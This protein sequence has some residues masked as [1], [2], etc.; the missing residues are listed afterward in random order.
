MK[1]RINDTVSC[2]VSNPIR[3]NVQISTAW[4]DDF[5]TT[6]F[7]PYKGECSNKA[8]ESIEENIR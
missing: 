2:K 7:K 8:F 1:E 5:P 4:A 3:E 6:G